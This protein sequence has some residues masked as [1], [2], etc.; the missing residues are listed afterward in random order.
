MMTI[1]ISTRTDAYNAVLNSG[2]RDRFANTAEFDA[3]VDAVWT[4][5]RD[6]VISADQFDAICDQIVG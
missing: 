2:H 1:S 4:A 3:A 6:G 5:A